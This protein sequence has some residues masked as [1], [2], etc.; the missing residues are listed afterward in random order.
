MAALAVIVPVVFAADPNQIAPGQRVDVRV[1]LLSADGTEPNFGAWKTEL[2]REGVP[3]D[4][5][6]IYNGTTKAQ[7][8]TDGR[9]A[10]YGAKHAKYDAV[11]LATG[12]LVHAVSNVGGTQSYLSALTDAEWAALAKFEQTFGIRQISDDTSPSPAHG[13]NLNQAGATLDGQTANLTATGKAAFPYL[14]GPI[15][16]PNDD[17]AVSEV[18]G[19]QGTPAPGADW[20][21]LVAGPANSAYLGIY[22]HPD[23]REEMVS[24]LAGNENQS[25]VQLLRHGMLNW[26]TR[27]VYLGYQRNYLELQVD[28]LFLGDDSWDPAT[29][30]NNYD[31]AAASRMTPADVTHA[32]AWSKQSGIRIDFAFNGGGSQLWLADH[33]G[34]GT[35]DPLADTFNDAATRDAFGWINHTSTHPNIDCST[36]PFITKQITDNITFAHQHNLPINPAEV[37]TGEHSGLAN[38][39]PGNPGTIDPPTIDDAVPAATGGTLSAGSYSYGITASTSHGETS[40]SPVGEAVTVPGPGA[41]NSV[42]V[43]FEAVCHA[44]KYTLYRAPAGTTTWTQVGSTT[45]GANDA[46]DD[47]VNP[48]QISITDNGSSTTAASPP[49]TN[50]AALDPYNQNPAL[51]AGLQA[52]NIHFVA[53]DAS[54]SYPESGNTTPGAFFTEGSG[55]GLVQAVPRYP[56]NVYYNVSK[57]SQQLDEYN[58]IYVLP[59]NGGG[60]VPIADVTT[61][62]TAAATWQQYVDSENTIMFRHVMGNDPRPHFMHQSNLADYNAA[63]PETDPNQGGILYPVVDGLLKRYDTA[64]DRG[65][66]P[67]V[68]LTSSQIAATLARQNAWAAMIASGKVTAYLQDGQ[69]HLA[70]GAAT[71]VD[72]PVTGTTA[73]DQYAGQRSG[74]ITLAAGASTTLSPS[75]PANATAPTVS[76]TARVGS[77]LTTGQGAWSGTAPIRYGYQWQ[78]CDSAGG[79]CA[80]LAGATQGAYTLGSAD[81]G[82]RLRV[83]VSAGNWI[84][85]VSQAASAP[86]DVI[87]QAPAPAA[88]PSSPAGGGG[89]HGGGAGQ[90]PSSVSVESGPARGKRAPRAVLTLTHLKMKPRRFRTAH[91]RARRGTAVDGSRVTFRVNRRATVRL[92]TQRRTRRGRHTRWVTVGTISRR[93]GTGAG[94]IRFNGRFRNRPL[95]PG[96]YRLTASARAG[97][98]RSRAKHTTF[99]VMVP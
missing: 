80:N 51:L 44:I 64:F 22:T 43:T 2:A 3:Y 65:S 28:D 59:A 54:K 98:L 63:L 5:V 49:A 87:A 58:W 67:L 52:A 95:K 83:V 21:T 6:Q 91:R 29:H 69:L 16:I 74:W 82:A 8:I 23:G 48:I 17:P 96:S 11:I 70:N 31:P 46:T 99:R 72:V 61:C 18:F 4:A 26:V 75:D 78:R 30:T 73:G 76:G 97:H 88:S 20:Q 94:T 27:G 90:T 35:T 42:T 85:S 1:L 40:L 71:S 50:G 47:G 12:D 32:V 55:N 38:T 60:C 14:K 81:E 10:D 79:H 9:L 41:T 53:T 33:P 36:A 92:V 93:V 39:R 62:R 57:Q 56:S 7:T 24:T 77:T 19:Y 34:A 13:L 66:A 45:R 89:D 37:V 15:P 84:S 86:S 25:Q 68:Q